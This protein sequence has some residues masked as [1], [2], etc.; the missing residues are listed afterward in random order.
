MTNEGVEVHA[1]FTLCFNHADEAIETPKSIQF[2]CMTK[3]RR[4]ERLAKETQR[5]VVGLEGDWM[6]VTVFAAVCE[7]ETC[8]IVEATGRAVNYFS[9]EGERL[10]CARAELLE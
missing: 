10:Q 2:V 6:R 4:I 3:L 7:S 5:L 8:R 9:N 1:W